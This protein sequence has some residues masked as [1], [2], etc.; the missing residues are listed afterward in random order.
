MPLMTF[1]TVPIPRL[2][3]F[4]AMA[5]PTLLECNEQER[6]LQL[7][8]QRPLRELHCVHQC[9]LVYLC[10]GG[11]ML[12][13]LYHLPAGVGLKEPDRACL[14]H[15]VPVE[16][17]LA[18]ETKTRAEVHAMFQQHFCDTTCGWDPRAESDRQKLVLVYMLAI[19]I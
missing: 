16:L 18:V 11:F 15:N 3:W 12:Y 10:M 7:P 5:A 4:L 6:I 13:P 1:D 19:D 2:M 9:K 14:R 17:H 8:L